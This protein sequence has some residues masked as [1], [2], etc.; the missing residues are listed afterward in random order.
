MENQDIFVVVVV[1]IVQIWF[2]CSIQDK[3]QWHLGFFFV[4]L[5]CLGH[6]YK[7]TM[8]LPPQEEPL[9]H[10]PQNTT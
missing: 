7:Q 3:K 9:L 6:S 4:L 2:I 8:S 1:V 10:M 5:Y